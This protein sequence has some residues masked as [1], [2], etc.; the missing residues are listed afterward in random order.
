MKLQHVMIDLETLGTCADAVIISV[1]AVKFD[2]Y[3]DALDHEGF[4]SSVSVDSN[5]EVAQRAIE[6]DTLVW[7]MRQTPHA[8]RVFHEPKTTLR[9]ALEELA[10][11]LDDPAVEV[12]A[13]GADFDLAIL[14]HAYAQFG[15]EVPWSHR[16][17]NCYRTFKKLPALAGAPALA[18][19]DAHHALADAQYQARQLQAWHAALGWADARVAA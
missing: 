17:T 10:H 15:M 9:C 11:Y 5:H 7:W 13:N 2:P 6:E 3:S 19:F 1:G 14:A 8:Q 4:Y 12:W 18:H 16:R